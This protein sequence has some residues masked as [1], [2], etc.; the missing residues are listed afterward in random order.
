[1]R[2]VGYVAYM[3]ERLGAYM[4]LMGKPKRKRPFGRA[5]CKWEDNLKIDLQ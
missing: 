1:M 4:V 3:G 2:W 5:T